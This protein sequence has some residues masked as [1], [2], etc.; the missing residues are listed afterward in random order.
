MLIEP[1]GPP[2]S[3]SVTYPDFLLARTSMRTYVLTE[4]VSNPEHAAIVE[5]VKTD[6]L[7]RAYRKPVMMHGDRY[8]SVTE[9]ARS[10]ASKFGLA[11]HAGVESQRTHISRICNAGGNKDIYFCE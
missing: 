6:N 4:V 7:P 2:M 8:K 3:D 9:A 1:T 5:L 11:D 10:I